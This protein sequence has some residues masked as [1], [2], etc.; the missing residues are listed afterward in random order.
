MIRHCVYLTAYRY[1]AAEQPY[2]LMQMVNR[3]VHYVLLDCFYLYYTVQLYT[4][5]DYLLYL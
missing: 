3:L 1:N 5:H 2:R 4:A